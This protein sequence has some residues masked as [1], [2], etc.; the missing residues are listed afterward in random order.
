MMNITTDTISDVFDSAWTPRASLVIALIVAAIVLLFIISIA[1]QS[2]KE[3]QSRKRMEREDAEN[4]KMIRS[5]SKPEGP[6]AHVSESDPYERARN[7][8]KDM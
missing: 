7:A 5:R 8:F 6:A 2:H 1:R 3:K 4:D